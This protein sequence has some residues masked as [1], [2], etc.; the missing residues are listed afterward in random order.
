MNSLKT[1]TV[2]WVLFYNLSSINSQQG[3]ND[4]VSIS[5]LKEDLLILKNNLEEVHP[6]LYAYHS[7]EKFDILFSEIEQNLKQPITSIDFYRRLLPILPLIANNHT[8][9]M[10]PLDYKE[11]LVTSLPRLP[12]RLYVKE[13]RLYLHED[14]SNEQIIGL[15]KEILSINGKSAGAIIDTIVN[16]SSKDGF[17]TS[18]AIYGLGVSFSRYYAYYFGTP[19]HFKIEYLEKNGTLKTANIQGVKVPILIERRGSTSISQSTNILEFNIT[20]NIAYLKINSFQPKSAGKFRKKLK[21]Y[22]KQIKEKKIEQLIIDVRGNGG[23]YGEAADEVF[24]YLIN[25]TVFTYKDEYALVDKIPYPQ[26]YEKDMFFKHFKKQPL[27]KKGDIYHIRNI[28]NQKVQP[29]NNRYQGDLYVMLDGASASATG[30]FLGLVK[31]YTNAI[32]IGQE[33]GGNPA[34]TTANDLLHMT[35]PNSKVRVTI[36]ALRSV[37]NVTFKNTGHGIIPDYEII[38][39]IHDIL[40]NNDIVLDFTLKLIHNKHQE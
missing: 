12:F 39:E 15:G 4:L 13:R 18:L 11:A 31:S 17:N 32:F 24:S 25:E 34:E 40:Q 7:K 29:K 27:V 21:S 28:K 1:I 22:F 5:E 38:P 3:Y 37:S 33:A 23:G 8:H 20:N 16:T 10:C 36:P 35:L 9:I 14:A 2:L 30:Q 6:G 19:K 26:Y